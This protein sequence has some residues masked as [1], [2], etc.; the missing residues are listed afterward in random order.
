MV[1]L[2]LPT[3]E[4]CWEILGKM[5]LP[6]SDPDFAKTAQTVSRAKAELEQAIA[7]KQAPSSPPAASGA[8]A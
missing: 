5:Q 7:E 6:V 8:G 4:L 1:D 2:S 3:L